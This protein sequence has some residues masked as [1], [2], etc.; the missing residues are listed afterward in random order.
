MF[1]SRLNDLDEENNAIQ[2]GLHPTL[3][4]QMDDIEDKHRALTL[5]AEKRRDYHKNAIETVFAA[6]EKQI[7]DEFLV[8]F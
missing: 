6:Q 4:K 3:S 7:K 5:R 1:V 8:I 2:E